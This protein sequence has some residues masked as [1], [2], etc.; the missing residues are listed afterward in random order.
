MRE[1][2]NI[3]FQ[4][5]LGYLIKRYNIIKPRTISCKEKD[6]ILEII[7]K[8]KESKLFFIKYSNKMKT[9][10]IQKLGNNYN[11]FYIIDDDI[12]ISKRI[13]SNKK[14]ITFE[15]IYPDEYEYNIINKNNKT[16]YDVEEKDYTKVHIDDNIY[17]LYKYH[18]TN[19]NLDCYITLKIPFQLYLSEWKLSNILLSKG[20]NLDNIEDVLSYIE[21]AL[22]EEYQNCFIN[23]CNTKTIK[24]ENHSIETYDGIIKTTKTLLEKEKIEYKPI[25]YNKVKRRVLE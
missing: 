17:R 3:L 9:I 1:E 19:D 25:N 14:G 12:H 7:F 10:S 21:F 5:I 24:N 22:G 16:Y 20:E 18:L 2:N 11:D 4:D 8:D 15:K 13:Y 23:I 6:N